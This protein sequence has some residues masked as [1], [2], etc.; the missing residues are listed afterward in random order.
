MAYVKPTVQEVQLVSEGKT[1]LLYCK[2]VA[3]GEQPVCKHGYNQA[4][5]RCSSTCY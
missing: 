1:S 5:F 4:N 2:A 3:Q